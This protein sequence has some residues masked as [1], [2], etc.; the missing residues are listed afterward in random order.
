MKVTKRY[1]LVGNYVCTVI[2]KDSRSD[3][4]GLIR[5]GGIPSDGTPVEVIRSFHL[6]LVIAFDVLA[7]LGLIYTTVCLVFNFVFRQRK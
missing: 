1:F 2:I 3:F 7:F 6:A 5:V 4:F